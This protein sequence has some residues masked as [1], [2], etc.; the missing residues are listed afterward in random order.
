MF[1]LG[2]CT[3]P[4]LPFGE[5]HALCT[6]ASP[7]VVCIASLGA[8]RL[9]G[10]TRGATRCHLSSPCPSCDLRRTCDRCASG[11]P[12]PLCGSDPRRPLHG[13]RLGRWVLGLVQPAPC[14]GP[15]SVCRTT[16]RLPMG[17]TPLG[18]RSWRLATQG[19]RL[20]PLKYAPPRKSPR[21]ATGAFCCAIC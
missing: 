6:L 3:A 9:C 16:L 14:L 11:S 2:M 10:C 18:A 15:W 17:C 5:H 13:C 1:T 4:R 20:G 8:Q 7:H 19:R 21:L 12:C